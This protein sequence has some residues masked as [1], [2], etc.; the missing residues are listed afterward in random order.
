MRYASLGRT[1]IELSRYGLGSYLYAPGP[2]AGVAWSLSGRP[3]RGDVTY[4][5]RRALI[6]RALALGV[7]LFDCDA[8]RELELNGRVFHDLH[9]RER[10]V[11]RAWLRYCPVSE[12]AADAGELSREVE[13]VLRLLRTEMVDVLVVCAPGALAEGDYPRRLADT[14]DTLIAAGRIRCAAPYTP[15]GNRALGPYIETQG[16]GAVFVTLG[17]L[18]PTA[19]TCG[20]TARAA[21]L[22]LGVL[23]AQPFLR[24]WVFRC[25]EEMG[26]GAGERAA[27]VASAAL[28]WAFDQPGV[29]AATTGVSGLEELDVNC[30]APDQPFGEKDASL[31]RK[32]IATDTYAAFIDLAR[33]KAYPDI[34]D[35]REDP[36][37]LG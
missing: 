11:L 24:G 14:C 3:P 30:R 7:T 27:D 21:E 1:G 31:L 29:C 9:C 33:E 36:E 26:W 19:A 8:E 23:C 22:E 4:E 32:L 13:R 18:N 10:I 5:E 15:D 37:A 16:F 2:A 35:W 20:I 25:A 12:E 17:L 28:R 6:E 34:H